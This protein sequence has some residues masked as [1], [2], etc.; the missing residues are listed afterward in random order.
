MSVPCLATEPIIW[1]RVLPQSQTNRPP[2]SVSRHPSGLFHITDISKPLVLLSTAALH[3]PLNLEYFATSN[4]SITTPACLENNRP[5]AMPRN[6]SANED[7]ECRTGFL[8]LRAEMRNPV[9]SNRVL[10]RTKDG[11]RREL[12][13]A[14]LRF[15]NACQRANQRRG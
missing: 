10:C 14:E 13:V 7:E 6:Y 11:E 1:I 9:Y 12:P 3:T 4:T 8:D 2:L 5:E 15:R